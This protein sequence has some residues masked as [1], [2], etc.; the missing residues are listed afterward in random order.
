MFKVKY[1]RRDRVPWVYENW[2]KSGKYDKNWRP[3]SRVFLLLVWVANFGC[4][5]QISKK[6]WIQE[7]VCKILFPPKNSPLFLQNKKT[8]E[9]T[10][11]A[12]YVLLICW[13][14]RVYAVFFIWT[15]FVAYLTNM[16][17]NLQN[18]FSFFSC[19]VDYHSLG[20]V[21]TLR[22]RKLLFFKRWIH[23]FIW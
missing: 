9:K 22:K 19:K 20:S 15:D 5:T 2:W 13:F 17:A 3:S 21:S 1:K 4:F 11:R 12:P 6:N 7:L 14:I 8:L 18:V 23:I 16:F 10:N